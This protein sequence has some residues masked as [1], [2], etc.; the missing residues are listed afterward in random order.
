V[1]DVGRREPW[2][3]LRLRREEVTLPSDIWERLRS[4]RGGRD[5]P[6]GSPSLG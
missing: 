4:V 3:E 5:G 6:A 1:G 2:C